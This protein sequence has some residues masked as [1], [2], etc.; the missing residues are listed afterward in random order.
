MEEG[1]EHR[2]GM[3]CGKEARQQTYRAL[4]KFLEKSVTYTCF[5]RHP[6]AAIILFLE[7]KTDSGS[8][9][10]GMSS[11]DEPK[12]LLEYEQQV[13]QIF[14]LEIHMSVSITIH[15]RTSQEWRNLPDTVAPLN[16]ECDL[17]S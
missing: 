10:R 17:G 9:R 12:L 8:L 11:V 2:V 15:R 3:S 4:Q 7:I 6:P 5:P 1:L 16:I 14:T 13:Q